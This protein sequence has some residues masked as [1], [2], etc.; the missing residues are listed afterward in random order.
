M[1]LSLKVALS[2]VV[3]VALGAGAAAIWV[4]SRTFEG[5]V[6]PDPFETATHFDEVRHNA[7][8]LGWTLSLEG[9]GLRTGS[10]ALRF[11]VASRGGSPL[12]GAEVRVKLSRP[13]TAWKDAVAAARPEGGG[14]FVAEV[15]F[16]EPGIWDLE[17]QTT[18]GSD[19]LAFERRVDVAR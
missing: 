12:E 19:R 13:G 7:E 6:V 17:I 16:P 1:S 18:R 9:A 3:A 5:T 10:Q 8:A 15:S 2:L 4:G 11:S 14:R